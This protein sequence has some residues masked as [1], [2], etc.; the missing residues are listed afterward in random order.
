MTHDRV[1]MAFNCVWSF[2]GFVLPVITL[3]YCNVHL[4]GAL[5]ESRRMRRVYMT[6]SRV[7]PSCGNRVTPTLVVKASAYNSVLKKRHVIVATVSEVASTLYIKQQ[8]KPFHPFH[9]KSWW[10]TRNSHRVRP[11]LVVKKKA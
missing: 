4:V 8:K 6:N 3:I 10:A 1:N 7:P 5:R 9:P 11:T 2:L